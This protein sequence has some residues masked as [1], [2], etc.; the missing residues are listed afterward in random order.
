MPADIKHLAL[1]AGGK[2]T[3]LASVAGAVPKV[4]VPVGGK[5]VLAHHLALAA[6]CGIDSV[7][8]FVGHR[9]ADIQTFVGDGAQFG[10]SVRV[11]V[12]DEPLGTAGAVMASLDLLPENFLLLYADVMAAVDLQALARFHHEHRADFTMLAH[13]NDH[14]LDSDLLEADADGR[15]T[16]LHAYPHPP[17]ACYANLVNAA[18]YAIRREALRPLAG[19][20]AKRDFIKDVVPGLIAAGARVFAY[21]SSEYLKDMGTPARLQQAESDYRAGRLSSRG[22]RRPAIF[23]DRDGTLNV[24]K[25]HIADLR[26]LKLYPGVAAA[27]RALRQ[28]GFRLI[29]VTNQSVIARGDAS[30]Q[31]VAA[32]HRRLEWELGKAGAFLDA[33]Y[34]CPHHPD[35]GFPGERPALKIAC[36]CRKPGIGLIER[37]CRDIPIDLS[38]SWVIGDQTRDIEM[39]R[40][41]GLRS[42]LLR[43]GLAS[44]DNAFQAKPDR[45]ADDLAVAAELIAAEREVAYS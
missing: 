2:G 43:T 26:H 19:A 31:D 38:A 8:I 29:L 17:Q 41:A 5:P 40:R 18:L 34:V 39:A 16:A 22:A 4:L 20:R 21:R 7:T 42:V 11:I 27:L 32:I 10:L 25:G 33:I 30:E 14:P 36:D 37:A 6:A 35:R 3:R 45:V 24:E 12:E 9:A 15:V 1:V 23:L 44:A 28:Q 13:P